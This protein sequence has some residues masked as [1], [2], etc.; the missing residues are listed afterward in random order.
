MFTLY[1]IRKFFNLPYWSLSQF[2]KLKVKQAVSF[3]TAFENII[4]NEAKRMGYDGVVCG[5]IHKAELKKINGI[6]YAN[7][8]DWVESLTALGENYDGSLEI[9]D[10]SKELIA[11]HNQLVKKPFQLAKQ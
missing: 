1:K 2:I 9:I 6:I 3:V 8:G 11:Q 10:W 5:H 7:D 4:A